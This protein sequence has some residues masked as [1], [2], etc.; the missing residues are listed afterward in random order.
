MLNR[1]YY[2]FFRKNL[3]VGEGELIRFLFVEIRNVVF[4][5]NIFFFIYLYENNIYFKILE[6]KD[7]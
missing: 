7:I 5:E 6:C 4:V 1:M 2:F 3:K